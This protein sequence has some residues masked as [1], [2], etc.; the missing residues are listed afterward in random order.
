MI[1]QDVINHLEAL[2]PI[3]YAEDFDNVGLLVGDKNAKLKGVLVT[4]DTLE[5]VVDEAILK[6]CNLIVSF[7]PIIFKG[8]KKLNGKTYVERVVMKAIKH[9]IAIYSMHTALDNAYLGVNDMI[10]NQLELKNKNILIPQNGTIKKLTTY[11]PKNEAEKLRTALF[12][13]GAG[14]IGNYDNCSF[15]T[16]GYGT[17][18]GN[19]TSSPT[20]GNKNEVHVELE[21]KVTVTFAKHLEAKILKTLFNTH[22]YEE[23]AYE[24]ITIENKNQHIGMG[25]IGELTTP[26]SEADFLN[27]LKTKMYTG[28]IRHS[29]FLNKNI[30]KVAVLGGSGSFAISAAKANGADAFVTADLKY[31]D[32]FSAEN[33]ILLADIGHY[34][35]EQFTKTLLVEYL[36]K[37][38]TNFAIILSNTNTNPVKYF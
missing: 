18:K 36:T 2:A 3:A 9:D 23:V 29:T 30:K 17:F 10:C 33:T 6:K 8:L 28:C 14:S 38:I 16:E 26:L 20:I 27:H 35:S 32:F 13:A 24:I 7:H 37:K 5:S 22:S 11:V 4:L 34:E 25:M 31:H 1:V 19:D 15:N 21:T 12:N